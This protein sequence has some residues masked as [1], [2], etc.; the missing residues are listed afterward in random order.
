MLSNVIVT[1][2][3]MTRYYNLFRQTLSRFVFSPIHNDFNGFLLPIFG[4][5]GNVT[6]ISTTS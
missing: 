4:N 1:D 2:V 5:L 6:F 3:V